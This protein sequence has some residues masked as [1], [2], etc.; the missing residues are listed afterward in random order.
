MIS[1]DL[2][3]QI[4]EQRLKITNLNTLDVYDEPPFMELSYSENDQPTIINIGK[5]ATK[6]RKNKGSKIV[7]P[8][9]HPVI[10]PF[11]NEV[12]SRG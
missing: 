3:I 4:W 1:H 5:S 9:S 10:P 7:N 8:F 11:L 6:S 12:K 2:Y